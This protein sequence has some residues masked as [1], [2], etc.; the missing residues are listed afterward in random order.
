MFAFL[1]IAGLLVFAYACRTFE[2]RYIAKLGWLVLL[3]ATYL[4]GYFLS[5]S[6]VAGAASVSL[7]FML[8]WVEILGRVRQLRIPLK[9]EVSHRFPPSR[10]IFPNLGEI[11]RE[12]EEMAFTEA[13]NT[14]WRWDEADHFVRL[15]YHAESRTQAAVSLAQQQEFAVSYVSVT[16]RAMDGRIFTTSNYPFSYTMKFSPEHK[17]NRFVA[18]ESFE[19]LMDAHRDFLDD[20][21]I[22]TEMLAEQDADHL[23][24]GLATDMQQQIQHNVSIGVLEPAG[25]DVFRYTWRG[26]WFL[27][28]QVVKDMMR[29]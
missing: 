29:V 10:D 24:D 17:L 1:I 25:E 13:E 18:A 3:A 14:G 19:E 2:N 11:S 7:W 21:E 26:C 5:G 16:S 4:G 15:F 20:N 27:W 12:V 8:P 6:H 23:G 9:N 22:T 28:L